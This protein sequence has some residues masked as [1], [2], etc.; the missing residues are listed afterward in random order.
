MVTYVTAVHNLSY[1]FA[2]N[3][4]EIMFPGPE[5]IKT[6]DCAGTNASCVTEV[7]PTKYYLYSFP[8][9]VFVDSLINIQFVVQVPRKITEH[10]ETNQTQRYLIHKSVCWGKEYQSGK[11]C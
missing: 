5:C 10:D 9:A 8:V 3:A 2:N 1:Y 4:G 7:V 6:F 11:W